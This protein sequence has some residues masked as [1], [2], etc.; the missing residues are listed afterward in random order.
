MHNLCGL[1]DKQLLFKRLLVNFYRNFDAFHL[2]ISSFFFR[3]EVFQ[4]MHTVNIH[5][6]FNFH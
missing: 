5:D 4:F 6:R 2:N 1:L 3:L